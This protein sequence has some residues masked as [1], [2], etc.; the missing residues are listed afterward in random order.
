MTQWW[1]EYKSNGQEES[2]TF[3]AS[4]S[5]RNSFVTMSDPDISSGVFADQN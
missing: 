3:K 2:A 4:V 1:L 5:S